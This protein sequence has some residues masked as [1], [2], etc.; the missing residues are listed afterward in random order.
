VADTFK[1]IASVTVGAGGAA[2]MDFTSI[3]A[4]FTDLI[5]Y[6][7]TRSSTTEDSFGI[8]FNNDST[9]NYTFRQINGNGSVVASTSGTTSNKIVGGRQPESGYTANTFGNN[10]FYIPNYAG[11][12]NKSVS[13]DG[14]NENNATTV[15]TQLTAGLYP[16]TT[17]I[18]RIDVIP[19]AGNFVQYSTATLYGIRNS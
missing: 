15:R 16:Q 7:S 11:S 14:V 1:K 4:T 5:L 18:S 8:R 19:D 10:S 17:A 13:V 6:V 9:T 12:A 2:S 3:P